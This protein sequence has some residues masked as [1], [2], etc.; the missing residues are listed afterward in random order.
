[1]AGQLYGSTIG[2]PTPISI[3]DWLAAYTVPIL[4]P[5][6]YVEIWTS[7]NA[8]YTSQTLLG[9]FKYVSGT[10]KIDRSN[11]IRRTATD[12][13]IL[14][15]LAN[16]PGGDLLPI[17]GT[18]DGWFSPYGNEMRIFK[19]TYV[20]GV[21]TYA[22]LGVFLID[23]V[24]INRDSNG[25]IFKGTMSDRMEWLSRLSFNYPWSGGGPGDVE[26]ITDAIY[27]IIARASSYAGYFSIPFP[28]GETDI[29]SA[30][31]PL[32]HYAIGDDPAKAATDLAS[33]YGAAL[34]FNCT[35]A[36]CLVVVPDPS[37][38]TS[39]VEYLANTSTSPYQISRA[40]SNQQVPNV[41]CVESSGTK[42][43]PPVTV[44]WW[45]S[46]PGSPT[47]FADAP[48][49]WTVP[50]Y[51]LPPLTGTY[52]VLLQKFT[53]NIQQGD[54]NAAQAMALAIGLTSI[55]SLEKST[56]TL[57]DQP[58]HD[59]DDVITVYN[60]KAGIPADTA[61]SL[62]GFNYILDQV[63]IDLS[64]GGAGAQAVGRLVWQP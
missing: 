46:Y 29:I 13:V 36:L 24:D 41:I 3:A 52:S 30:D 62:A 33:A 27:E 59:I 50:Q 51:T 35:G 16:D 20:S 8:G 23:E 39:C 43:N 26:T 47:F 1:M 64:A 19:G 12:I 17:A 63:M 14:N 4:R 6:G 56:F 54:P 37:S 45:D 18:N 2:V 48:A 5:L 9:T 44:F 40:I 61:L 55:G 21:A 28:V 7:I 10:V 57:R 49:D 15:D 22:Q 60:P 34:Y 42:A 31:A 58:A 32:A 25:M 53:T 11:I 38:I